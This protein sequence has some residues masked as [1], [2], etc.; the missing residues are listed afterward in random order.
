MYQDFYHYKHRA[1]R[2]GRNFEFKYLYKLLTNDQY[3]TPSNNKF[4]TEHYRI[5]YPNTTLQY[6]C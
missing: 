5:R 3:H 4:I 2:R 6:R 1:R